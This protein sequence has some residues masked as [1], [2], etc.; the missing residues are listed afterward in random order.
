[1]SEPSVVSS[2]LWLLRRESGSSSSLFL[3]VL[4][5]VGVPGVGGGAW[6]AAG[7]AGLS[8][9]AVGARSRTHVRPCSQDPCLPLR[10]GPPLGGSS[11]CRWAPR[12]AA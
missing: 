5:F 3:K 9:E 4:S 6:Q 1:M 7:R 10:P 2:D 12:F 8:E 11:T